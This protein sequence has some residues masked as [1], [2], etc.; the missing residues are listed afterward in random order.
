MNNQNKRYTLAPDIQT[1]ISAG[2]ASD[3]GALSVEEQKAF[4]RSL[5]R[6]CDNKTSNEPVIEDAPILCLA[7]ELALLRALS[8]NSPDGSFTEAEGDRVLEW[9]ARVRLECGTLEAALNGWIDIRIRTDGQ[10]VFKAVDPKMI[11][12]ELERQQ[13]VQ[14]SPG[15]D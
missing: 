15:L 5:C 12:A 13:G 4:L 11:L 14:S 3:K 8:R 1:L 2:P 7:E 9:A 10:L 6:R